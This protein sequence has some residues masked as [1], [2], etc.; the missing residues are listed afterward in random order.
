MAL[1]EALCLMQA[2]WAAP[3]SQ[4]ATDGASI[5]IGGSRFTPLNFDTHGVTALGYAAFAFALGV[6]AG[7]LI[8]LRPGRRTDTL[9]PLSP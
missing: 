8:R 6:T 5:G 7:A 2:W 1:T 9:I 3:I 4:A